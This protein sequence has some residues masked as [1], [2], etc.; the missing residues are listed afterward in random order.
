ML[1][2]VHQPLHRPLDWYFVAAKQSST[3]Y[4]DP[5]NDSKRHKFL[6]LNWQKHGAKTE[7]W[8]SPEWNS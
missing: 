4:D 3:S 5:K 8:H 2:D 7:V 6:I 1:I